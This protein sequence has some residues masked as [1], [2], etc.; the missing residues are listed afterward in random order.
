MVSL[1]RFGQKGL[2]GIIRY[3]GSS[4]NLDNQEPMNLERVE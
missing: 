4:Q 3:R 1:R 2:M